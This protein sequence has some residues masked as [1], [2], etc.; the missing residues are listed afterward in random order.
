MNSKPVISR[1]EKGRQFHSSAGTPIRG[2]FLWLRELSG[3]KMLVLQR[4]KG[5]VKLH[6]RAYSLEEEEYVLIPTKKGVALD[7]QQVRDLLSALAD[8]S[9]VIKHVSTLVLHFI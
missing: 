9:K 4:Y 1:G 7:K 6:I 3:Q 5:V 2:K 8:L